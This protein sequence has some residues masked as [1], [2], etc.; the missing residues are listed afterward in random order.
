MSSVPSSESYTRSGTFIWMLGYAILTIGF[1]MLF[2]EEERIE[3]K[4]VLLEGLDAR[5]EKLARSGKPTSR[6]LKRTFRQFKK[7]KLAL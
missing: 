5:D 2:T 6:V 7:R 4:A 3:V 1:W